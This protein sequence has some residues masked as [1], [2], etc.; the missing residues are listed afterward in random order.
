MIKLL[1]LSLFCCTTTVTCRL[2]HFQGRKDDELRKTRVNET[3]FAK[4]EVVST[5]VASIDVLDAIEDDKD[6]PFEL[7][8]L[9]NSNVTIKDGRDLQ[10]VNSVTITNY[11]ASQGF[12]LVIIYK[13]SGTGLVKHKGWY[14]IPSNHQVHFNDVVDGIYSFYA[15]SFDRRYE[16]EGSRSRCCQ[17]LLQ[18]TLLSG[19]QFHWF[20]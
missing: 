13:E 17:L 8:N 6:A 11:C 14:T 7:V 4:N 20:I 10:S 16:W 5:M 2:R 15:V 12:W 1:F 9:T 19:L 3:F 18:W